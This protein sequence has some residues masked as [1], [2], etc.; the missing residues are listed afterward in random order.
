MSVLSGIPTFS[1]VSVS[2]LN[3]PSQAVDHSRKAGLGVK[4]ER[5]GLGV[6]VVKVML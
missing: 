3:A 4:V 6:S 2:R 5:V 1:L